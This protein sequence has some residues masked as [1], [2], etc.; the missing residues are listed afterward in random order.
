MRSSTFTTFLLLSM[1]SLLPLPVR[2]A[3]WNGGDDQ[4]ELDLESGYDTNTVITLSGMLTAVSFD[5]PQPQARVEMAVGEGQV[6]VVLGPRN[7]WAEHGIALKIGDQVTVRGA[8]AQGKDGVVYLLAQ[9][10][11]EKSRGEEVALRSES[12]QPAWDGAGHRFVQHGGRSGPLSQ[13]VHG[14][15]GGGRMGH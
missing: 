9:H 2:A 1:L 14:M 8:K 4:R 3:W 15:G 11:S 10:L 7:Y 5:G 13:H 12:G 6:T